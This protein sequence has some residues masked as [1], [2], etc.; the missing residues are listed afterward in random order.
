LKS[1]C[2]PVTTLIKS[3]KTEVILFYVPSHYLLKTTHKLPAKFVP[4]NP[5]AIR[6]D[7]VIPYPPER[8]G[9]TRSLSFSKAATYPSIAS[10]ISKGI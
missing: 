3:G 7:L 2:L 8:P 4:E 10:F 5:P 1:D 9:R 6:G